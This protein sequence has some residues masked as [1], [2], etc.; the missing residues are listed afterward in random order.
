MGK[1]S[2]D[3]MTLV[4]YTF[5]MNMVSLMDEQQLSH[6]LTQKPVKS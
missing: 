3:R 1:Y 4:A 6:Y 2:V 5:L